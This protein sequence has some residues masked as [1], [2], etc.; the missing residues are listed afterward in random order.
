MADENVVASGKSKQE[1]AYLLMRDLL[2][3][4]DGPKNQATRN[5]ILNHYAIARSAVQGSGGSKF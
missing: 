4:S 2:L 1:V 5:E 3:A